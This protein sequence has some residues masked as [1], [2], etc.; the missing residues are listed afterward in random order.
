MHSKY[1]FVVYTNRELD[2]EYISQLDNY[3]AF[4][5]KKKRIGTCEFLVGF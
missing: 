2:D 4:A 3:K 1:E 5:K